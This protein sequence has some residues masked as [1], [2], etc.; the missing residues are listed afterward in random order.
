MTTTDRWLVFCALALFA[1][2]AWLTAPLQPGVPALQLTFSRE[3][4]EGV[5][6]RW[7]AAGEDWRFARHFWLDYPFA[8]LYGWL[9]WRWRHQGLPGWLL[10][11][12]AGADLLENTLHVSFLLHPS[13]VPEGAYLLAGGAAMVKFKLLAVATL[14]AVVARVRRRRRRSV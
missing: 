7:A 10:L 5:L 9:G 4:F 8:L 13:A 6:S 1:G 3:G 2:M 11:G 14:V 12:A